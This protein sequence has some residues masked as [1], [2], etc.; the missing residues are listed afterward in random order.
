M[1]KWMMRVW[2]LAVVLLASGI[3]CT[4]A[5]GDEISV[6]LIC[7][8]QVASGSSFSAA[9][10]Y[11][12]AS[13][14]AADVEISY[15]PDVLE[16]R[17]CSGGEGFAAEEGLACIRLS[18]GD[19]KNY[20]SC[21][22]RFRALREGESFITVTTADLV[23][24]DGSSLAAETRSVKVTVTAEAAEAAGSDVK[25][26]PSAPENDKNEEVMPEGGLLGFCAWVK[27]G[28]ED[29]SFARQAED[30]VKYFMEGLSAMEFLVL[31]LCVSLI[32]LLLI[33]LA[34]EKRR[35]KR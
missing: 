6:T 9:L 3:F 21:K 14:G 15:D 7:E 20:L 19:G 34:A 17:S 5:Y 26:E 31:S 18:G 30:G 8:E 33:L 13:F 2:M 32:L 25:A 29:G 35:R 1:K 4:T 10:E 11:G 24:P 23:S 22:I 12:G 16:F 27:A 28:I